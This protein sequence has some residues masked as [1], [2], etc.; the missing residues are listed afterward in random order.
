MVGK[1]GAALPLAVARILPLVVQLLLLRVV[2]VN[3]IEHELLRAFLIAEQRPFEQRLG[4]LLAGAGDR[5]GYP[6][7]AL[8]VLVLPDQDIEDHAVD[9]VVGTEVGNHPHLGRALSKP[10]NPALALLVARGVPRQVVV[11]Y[12]IEVLLQI[13]PFGEAVG[14]DQH[15]P[16]RLLDERL[17]ASLSLR[18]W[19][20]ASD[21]FHGRR[22]QHF[23]QMVEQRTPRYR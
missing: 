18:R 6:E 9:R 11:E 2:L 16:S 12:G 17:D 14:A 1:A 21:R 19:E 22:P 3:E 10:I 15:E 4:D 13:D 20:P 8:Y 5:H 23:A 7:I